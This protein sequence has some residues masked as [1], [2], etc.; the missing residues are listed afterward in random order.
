M[1]TDMWHYTCPV[2]GHGQ[3]WVAQKFKGFES[4]VA[5]QRRQEGRWRSQT[6][7]DAGTAD[8]ATHTLT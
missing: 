3:K 5:H 6:P 7:T 1:D 8:A 4:F 2:V